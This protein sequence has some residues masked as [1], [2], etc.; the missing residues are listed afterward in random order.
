A[1]GALPGETA[2]D[3]Q[4]D[5]FIS[6]SEQKALGIFSGNPSDADGTIGMGT[7]FDGDTLIGGALHEITHAMGRIP[8]NSV[9]SL[10]RY[11]SDGTHDFDGGP[12]PQ[13]SSY[14]SIDGGTTVL[15]NFGT[16][17]DPSDWLNDPLVPNDPFGEFVDGPSLSTV[18]L[19][20]MDVLGF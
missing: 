16:D 2:L 8:G 11:L 4:S 15:A 18:D 19:A 7:G 9:L 12:T 20:V 1:L 14:F 3:G 5:F 10:F 17:S 6:T 13:A